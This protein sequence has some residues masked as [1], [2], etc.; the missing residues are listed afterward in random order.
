MTT[1]APPPAVTEYANAVRT[2]LAGLDPE[3]LD[4][5]TGGLEADL[6]EALAERMPDG[7]APDLASVTAVFGS[8]SA[9]AEELRAAAGVELPPPGGARR[10]RSVGDVV[11]TFRADLLADWARWRAENRWFGSIVDFLVALRPVWW[12]ARGWVVFMWF[13][14]TDSPAPLGRGFYQHMALCGLV[15][16]SVL[17][18]QRRIGQ[19]KWLRRAA[20]G[21]STVAALFFL[22][23]LGIVGHQLGGASGYSGASYGIGYE[24]GYLDGS[25]DGRQQAIGWYGN[26]AT[27]PSGLTNLFVYGP[28]GQPI[29]Y[30]QIVDQNGNPFVLTNPST[31]ESWTTRDGWTW[32]GEPMPAPVLD[33]DSLNVYPW[34]YLDPEHITT[35]DDGTVT[36]ETSFA[37]APR[38][39]AA[40][41]FPVPAEEG[42]TEGPSDSVTVPAEETADTNDG[43]TDGTEA[44]EAPDSGEASD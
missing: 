4:E 7:G 42:A 20:L 26:G 35:Q 30:A 13:T 27:A 14:G 41:L 18:G 22:P 31:D 3:T 29:E 15:I 24:D 5:L 21:V 19:Q 12:V 1:L 6:A 43:A 40:T 36:G 23:L 17:W 34:R 16:V 11:T 39:P 38:W 8:S 10:R 44:D 33:G 25:N 2:H 28:D 37:T 32:D 9:Y